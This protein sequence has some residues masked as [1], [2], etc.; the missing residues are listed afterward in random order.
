M[1]DQPAGFAASCCL[2]PDTGCFYT[3]VAILTTLSGLEFFTYQY[4]AFDG[5]HS[6]VQAVR[7]LRLFRALRILRA[8]KV[9][10]ELV[11]VLETLIRSTQKVCYIFLFMV[12]DKS[13]KGTPYTYC[14]RHFALDAV[15]NLLY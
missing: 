12:R 1:R 2:T 11:L 14:I 13:L 3:D 10:P 7:L 6:A 9:M 15:G 4:D 5:G 8:A